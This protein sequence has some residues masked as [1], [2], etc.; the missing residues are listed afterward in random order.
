MSWILAL[1]AS[2]PR[3]VLAI[4]RA[5][6]PVIAVAA[7]D[8]GAN[9]ASARLQSRILDL[10]A[11]AGIGARGIS[12]VACGRG[13]GTFTGTRVAVA[14]AKGIALGLGVPV[15]PVST[16]AA[17]A[18]SVTAAGMIV[19]LLDAR[20]GEVYGA[21]FESD[22]DDIVA[23]SEERC[24]TL[25]DLVASFALAAPARLVGPGISAVGEQL[26]AGWPTTPMAGPTPEGLWR[27]AASA[28]ARGDAA[29]A[30]EID[31]IYLRA[32]YA[33]LGVN[34]PKRKPFKSPF[35]GG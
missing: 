16:L 1:D 14:T 7:D 20:R 12:A 33:E 26:P 29:D 8:D 27:A 25:V 15:V 28:H 18:A 11:T 6:G 5:G 24:A 10:L 35:A 13:P 17:V 34:T 30:A 19:P 2:T 23:R 4:G 9:Q 32:S 22:G 31:A 3:S 21:L